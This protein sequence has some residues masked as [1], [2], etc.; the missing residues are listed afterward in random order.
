MNLNGNVPPMLLL[1][2]S[3]LTILISERPLSMSS[4]V[5]SEVTGLRDFVP[6]AFIISSFIAFTSFTFSSSSL[7]LCLT[8]YSH[9]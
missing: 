7:S 3:A 9:H 8:F 4:Q 6:S 1:K 5:P 2:N